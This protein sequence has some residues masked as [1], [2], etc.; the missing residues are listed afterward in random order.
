M[1]GTSLD[2]KDRKILSELDFR[3]REPNSAIA[4]RVALSKQ[5]VDYRIRQL[6]RKGIIEGYYPIINLIKLGYVYGRFFLKLQNI[7]RQK[8]DEIQK[9]VI[10]DSRFKWVLHAEGAYNLLVGTWGKNLTEVKAASESLIENYGMYIKE[11]KE[12]IGINIAHFES[13]YLLN[14]AQTLQVDVGESPVVE[15]D[16]TDRKILIALAE[17]ARMPMVQIAMKAK[18]SPRVAAARIKK[19][20]KEKVVLG[21]RP[22]INH[23]LLGFT[24]YKLLFY[25]SNVNEKEL[26]KFKSYLKQLPQVMYIV[27]ELGIC[28][29]DIEVMLPV[30]QSLFE[31]VDKIRFDF[32]SLIRDYELIILKKTLKI[33]YLPF[34]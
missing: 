10:A 1:S 25:L 20:R 14:T 16:D 3:A 28:D 11:K 33:N 30:E 6:E 13:R 7:S 4:K 29:V 27:D 22:N 2:L 9:E 31:F 8:E 18:V 5:G 24:H 34:D 23:N 15:I 21:Y 17:D 12:S 19:L 26:R 32:P